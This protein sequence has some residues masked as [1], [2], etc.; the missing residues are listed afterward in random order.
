LI[1]FKRSLLL[2]ALPLTLALIVV[3]GLTRASQSPSAKKAAARRFI[4]LPN[5]TSTAPFSEGV[6]VRDTLYLSGRLGLDPAT[7]KPPAEIEAEVRLIMEG[8][9]SVLAQ[10]GMTMDD[11]VTVTVY[12]PDLSLYDQFNAVY[13]TYFTKDPP[14]RAFIGSGPLLRGARFEIQSIAVR[15]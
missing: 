12:C 13:K 14:A 5:R 2:L 6:L 7:G 9:K 8:M 11:L 3:G 1:A 10:A 4:N 15:R